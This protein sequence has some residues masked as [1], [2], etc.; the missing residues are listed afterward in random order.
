MRIRVL[1]SQRLFR[2]DSIREGLRGTLLLTDQRLTHRVSFRFVSRFQGAVLATT[3]VAGKMLR[4]RFFGSYT[5]NRLGNGNV[6][7]NTFFQIIMIDNGYQVFGTVS[8]LTRNISTFVL[9]GIIL[10]VYHH[11]TPRWRQSHRRMLGT[12]ITI[13]QIV[14]QSFFISSTGANFINTGNRFFSVHHHF[15]YYLRLFVRHRHHFGYHLKIRLH[16]RKS[17]RRRVLRSMEAMQALRTRQFAFGK[18]IMR[19]PCQ[20]NRN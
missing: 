15:T 11:W 5:I 19:T 14:R 2:T 4:R 7:S 8:L 1:V 20:H 18:S 10:M 17:F 6:N 12:I 3:D 13:D 16:Q 9:H